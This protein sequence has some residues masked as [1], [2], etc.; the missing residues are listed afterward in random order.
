MV[1]VKV[2][3]DSEAGMMPSTESIKAMLGFNEELIKAGIMI[4]GDGLRPSSEGKRVL[5]S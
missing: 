3:A 4:S 1:L 2:T 5:K